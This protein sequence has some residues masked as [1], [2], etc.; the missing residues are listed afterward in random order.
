LAEIDWHLYG[1]VVGSEY[2]KKVLT[3]MSSGPKSPKQIS[4]GT[5]LH[6]NHVS[7]TLRYLVRA[8]AVVCLTPELR[9]GKL[10]QLT[11]LGQQIVKRL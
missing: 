9:K 1:L 11:G 10:F 2:R 3:S 4:I 7:G 5:G 8:G 6:L